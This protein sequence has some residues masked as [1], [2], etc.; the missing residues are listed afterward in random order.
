[1]SQANRPL[2]PHLQV[3][4]FHFTMMWSIIHRITGL[5][6]GLGTIWLTWWLIA[7]ATGP[8]AFDAVQ[9]FSGTFIGRL[10]LFGFTWALMFHTLNGVRHLFWDIGKGFEMDTVEA[11]GWAVAIGSVVLTLGIWVYGYMSMGV[12]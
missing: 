11:T 10:L 7:A 6:L 9:I 3:Y 5:G 12:L 2:S 4:T 8:E 1:M